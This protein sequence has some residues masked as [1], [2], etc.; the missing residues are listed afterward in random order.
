MIKIKSVLRGGL[1]FIILYFLLVVLFF[2][3]VTAAYLIPDRIIEG[4]AKA[5]LLQL[6][7]EGLWPRFLG[8]NLELPNAFLNL[9]RQEEDGSNFRGIHLDNNTDTTM[10]KTAIKD[11]ASPIIERGQVASYAR[12]WHG[13]LVFLRPTLMIMS[14]KEIRYLNIILLWILLIATVIMIYKKINWITAISFMLMMI[15]CSFQAVPVSMQFSSVFYIM[16]ASSIFVMMNYEKSWFERGL[17]Q[18]FFIVGAVTVFIDFLTAPVLTLGIPMLL[19]LL[20]RLHHG[21]HSIKD[22]TMLL[23]KGSLAWALGYS[24]LWISKW[25]LGSVILKRNVVE[26][27]L[28]QF[29][30]RIAGS[31]Q[32]TVNGVKAIFRN[33][34]YLTVGI[35]NKIILLMIIYLFIVWVRAMI[36]DENT[37]R[38]FARSVPVL[39]T[40]TL[41]FGWIVMVAG[42]SHVH[43]WFTYRILIIAAMAVLSSFAY[44]LGMEEVMNRLKKVGAWIRRVA[45]DSAPRGEAGLHG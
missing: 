21:E 43:C 36:R 35:A 41:P 10:I 22:D 31:E 8:I 39:L 20:M 27:A 26:N 9:K 3:M 1:R 19:I 44:S 6:E 5:S 30:F 18:F 15:L 40:A 14:I 24:M 29:A 34:Y 38:R 13:Y 33:G 32:L 7:K 37:R 28:N 4:N 17:P 16:F 12:Y 23:V 11:S 25:L 2:C 45:I 42:H